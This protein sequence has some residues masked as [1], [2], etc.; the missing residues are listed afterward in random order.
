M[1]KMID[2]YNL[3]VEKIIWELGIS[4]DLPLEIIEMAIQHRREHPTKPGPAFGTKLGKAFERA[5][6]I[7]LFGFLNNY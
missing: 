2:S 1:T 6:D 4:Y 5:R 3:E 7:E